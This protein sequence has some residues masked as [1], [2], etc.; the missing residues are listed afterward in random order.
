M[1]IFIELWNPNEKF[2]QL[3]PEQQ[4]KLVGQLVKSL[5]DLDGPGG[6][7]MIGWG[8]Q[9][10]KVDHQLPYQLFALWRVPD[11]KQLARVQQALQQA[12]WYEYVNQVNV[13][14]ELLPSPTHLPVYAAVKPK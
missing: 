8:T 2:N 1:L 13:A 10:G 5:E 7:E 12:G 9:L 11:E 14:G 3:T 6:I 4:Q